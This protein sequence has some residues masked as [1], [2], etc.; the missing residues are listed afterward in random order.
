MAKLKKITSIVEVAKQAG[1]SVTTA[2]RALNDSPLVKPETKAQIVE[3]S[4]RLGYSLSER[5]PG[6]KP[7][8]AGRKRKIAFLRFLD[9]YHMDLDASAANSSFLSLQRGVDEGARE[10]GITTT[11]YIL[12]TEDELPDTIADG[13]Y[14]GFLLLGHRPHVSVEDFLKTRPCCWV[15]SNPWRPTWGDHVKPD[16]WE[17]G[18]IA[19]EYLIAHGCTAP[20]VIKL[21]QKDR[22]QVLREQGFAYVMARQGLQMESFAAMRPL[23]DEPSAFPEAICVD[24]IVESLKKLKHRPDSFF[25]DC[26]RTLATL[27]PVLV[28]ER[29]IVPGSTCLIG[30][31]NQMQYLRGINPYPATIEIHFE[32]VG[33]LGSAQLAWRMAHQEISQ[34]VRATTSPSLISLS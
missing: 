19:A 30:C 31:D 15:M 4:A 25:M 34:R 10:N 14:N 7:G 27:Y 32:L 29:L 26:D 24:E 8:G 21:G 18:I 5:R 33:R 3:I 20:V 16:H 13:G 1:V 2:S 22:V 12:S 9:R 28:N 17:A 6:P 11:L 23:S